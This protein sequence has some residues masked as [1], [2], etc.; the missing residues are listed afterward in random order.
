MVSEWQ[1]IESAPKDG[2]KIILA[3]IREHWKPIV[4]VGAWIDDA[5]ISTN[6]WMAWT[7]I[8]LIGCIEPTHW[9]PLPEPPK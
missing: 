8:G 4:T 2:T 5:P 9:M 1:P 3:F 6:E 7:S